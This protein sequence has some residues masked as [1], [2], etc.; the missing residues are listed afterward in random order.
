VSV[1]PGVPVFDSAAGIS[2]RP[3]E[4]VERG[5]LDSIPPLGLLMHPLDVI[6][7]AHARDPHARLDAVREYLVDRARRRLDAAAANLLAG[8]S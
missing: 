3:S 1:F 2:I 6:T 5:Q 4:L 8:L 7:M